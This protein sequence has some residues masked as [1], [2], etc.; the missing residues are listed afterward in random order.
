MVLIFILLR[1]LFHFFI[2]ILFI[3]LFI[4][5]AFLGILGGVPGFLGVFR[6]FWG[7]CSGFSG[8]GVLSFLEGVPGFRWSSGF[9]GCS[10]TFRCSGVPGSTTCHYPFMYHFS[11]KR[12]P[13][14]I[15]SIDKWYTFHIPCLRLCI[16]VNCCKCTVFSIGISH[17]NKTFS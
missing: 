11:R 8:G 15:P 7:R 10:G 3:Y 6:V 16:P 17:K 13:F 1:V 12:Y 2:F 9:L 14:H 4:F 5:C